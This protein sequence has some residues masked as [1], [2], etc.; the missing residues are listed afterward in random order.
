MYKEYKNIY[1]KI[2]ERI[3][4]NSWNLSTYLIDVSKYQSTQQERKVLYQ[5]SDENMERFS[6]FLIRAT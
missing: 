2:H 6:N 3:K 1:I 5:L 4:G